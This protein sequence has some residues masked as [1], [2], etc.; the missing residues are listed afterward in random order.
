MKIVLTKVTFK[1]GGY[2]IVDNQ[3][4]HDAQMNQPDYDS[5][6]PASK[7][8][9]KDFKEHMAFMKTGQK[10]VDLI[11]DHVEGRPPLTE[12]FRYDS[13]DILNLMAF[14]MKKR[15]P[16]KKRPVNVEVCSKEEFKERLGTPPFAG[17]KVIEGGENVEE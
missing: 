16:V 12:R 11:E 9:I 1:G 13:N 2:I 8:E 3:A 17:L 14:L 5:S 10:Y 6:S 15:E 7:Q 4:D